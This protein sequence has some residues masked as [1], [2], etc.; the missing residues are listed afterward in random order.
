[1]REREG[2]EAEGKG[3]ER[4]RSKHPDGLAT[5]KSPPKPAPWLGLAD[6]SRSWILLALFRRFPRVSISLG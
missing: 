6:A 2:R 3:E 5:H 1:M 4:E